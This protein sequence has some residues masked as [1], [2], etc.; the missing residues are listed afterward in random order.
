MTELGYTEDIGENRFAPLEALTRG[1]AAKLLVDIFGGGES[2]ESASLFAGAG[3]GVIDFTGMFDDTVGGPYEGFSGEIADDPYARVLLLESN[4]MRVAI[5]TLDLV[6]APAEAIELC[7]DYVH[8]ITGTPL[9]NI[10]VHATHVISTPHIGTRDAQI[11]MFLSACTSAITK[12]AKQA[13]DSFQPAVA[14]VG[15]G[16][17][18]VNANRNVLIDGNYYYGLGSTYGESNKT[19]T[20]LRVDSTATGDPIGF[21]INYGMKPD[22]I[23]NTQMSVNGRAISADAPGYLC[24]QMESKYGAPTLYFMGDVGDQIPQKTSDYYE[25]DPATG[26]ANRVELSVAEG[27]AF[28][29]EIGDKMMTVAVEITDSINTTDNNPTIALKSASFSW[30]NKDGATSGTVDV[31]SLRMGDDLAI[32]GLKPEINALTGLALQAA[33]PFA[34]TMIVS[35]LDGDQRYMPD[36][37]AYADNTREVSRTDL[38]PG[39]AEKFVDVSLELLNA[40]KIIP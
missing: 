15:A 8:K 3:V 6:N 14:G 25:A 9:N 28:A 24:T 40:L 18:D 1:V 35:F 23:N 12:A 29:Q 5:V 10:W 4:R 27:L 7:R 11:A 34:H 39:A 32:V 2:N 19:M 30:P 13:I 22:V 20:I 31:K 21:I 37:Q 33:S 36:A 16:I 26:E 38:S 17:C